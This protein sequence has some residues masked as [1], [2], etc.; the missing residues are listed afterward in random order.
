MTANSRNVLVIGQGSIGARHSD[1]LQSLGYRPVT[2]SR[3]AGSGQFES[4]AAAL[5]AVDCDAAAIATETARHAADLDELARLRF[6]GRIMVEKPLVAGPQELAG[7]RPD[8][9]IFVG[10]N[11]RFLPVVMELQALLQAETK[12][13]IAAQIH[14]GQ[15][16]ESWRLGRSPAS[17]Y[18]AHSSQG[19]GA[20]RDLSHELDLAMLL[21]GKVAQVTAVGGRYTEQT[22]D[23]DDAWSI[24]AVAER[25]RQLT[26]TLNGIDAEP[27]RYIA[28]TTES[29]RYHADLINGVLSYAGAAHDFKSAPNES[30]RR[31]WQS[32]LG[33]GAGTPCDWNGGAAVVQ[34]IDAIET[35]NLERRWVI[36]VQ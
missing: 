7:R 23:S 27:S 5:A 10:Y 1:V 28:V 19:G 16:Y 22:V 34:L 29:R 35:A 11:L 32:L 8:G 3:R 26:M 15:A 21:F 20:L 14:V 17:V 9:P 12:P 6:G 31:M 24:L 13:C 30:Y 25:C 33:E 18:S 4:I 2:V 36:P